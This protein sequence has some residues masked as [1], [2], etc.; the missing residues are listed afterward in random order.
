MAGIDGRRRRA[1]RTRAAVVEALLDLL[2]AGELRPRADRIAERA[3]VS[4]RSLFQHFADLEELHAAVADR[5]LERIAL[6]IGPPAT[7]GSL[8]ARVA[9]LAA[10]RAAL[11]E[12]ITPVRRAALLHEPFSRAIAARLAGM[13][14]S[15]R[16]DVD[17]IFPAELERLQPAARREL[18]DAL[19]M[20]SSFSA[21]EH[22]RRHAGA[23]AAHAE[24]VVARS[25]L[26]LLTAARRKES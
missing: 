26:A 18:R 11:Y 22:L 25:L 5:Q 15:C 7:T 19:C 21:W 9:S 4:T 14:R 10:A 2:E 12:R 17:R 6:E 20:A 1:F 8:A 16:R 3:G 24:R 13:R 23:S